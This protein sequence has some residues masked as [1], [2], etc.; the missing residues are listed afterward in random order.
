MTNHVV[1]FGYGILAKILIEGC[2]VRKRIYR[3]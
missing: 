1:L 2:S 3:S